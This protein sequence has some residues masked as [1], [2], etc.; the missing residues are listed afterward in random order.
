MARTSSIKVK[1]QQSEVS[2]TVQ[3][4][5][6]HGLVLGMKAIDIGCCRTLLLR[7]AT[8][9]LDCLGL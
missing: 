3:Q 4:Q 1:S 5:L 8:S 9:L 2:F 7:R 6:E